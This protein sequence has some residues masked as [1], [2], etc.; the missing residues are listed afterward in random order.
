M[1]RNGV[2]NKFMKYG[3]YNT[4]KNRWIT[5]E[6][7]KDFVTD[8]LDVANETLDSINQLKLLGNFTDYIY[9]IREYKK[10]DS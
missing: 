2:G 1:I 9:E 3:I 6:W 7:E 5:E 10:I 4:N 8:S